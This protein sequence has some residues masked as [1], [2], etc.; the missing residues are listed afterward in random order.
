[1]HVLPCCAFGGGLLLCVASVWR[2]STERGGMFADLRRSQP[3]IP[4]SESDYRMRQRSVSVRSEISIVVGLCRRPSVE[5]SNLSV[6]NVV[7][8]VEFGYKL[9]LS[10]FSACCDAAWQV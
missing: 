3:H 8:Q 9:S 2:I 6:G 4:D 5:A 7:R 1:M 10:R